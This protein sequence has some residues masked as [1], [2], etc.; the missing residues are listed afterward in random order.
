MPLAAHLTGFCL[1]VQA[2]EFTWNEL[3][4]DA[5]LARFIVKM[6]DDGPSGVDADGDGMADEVGEV[7]EVLW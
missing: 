2:F 7:R 4:Q 3:M 6:D 1:T 5:R